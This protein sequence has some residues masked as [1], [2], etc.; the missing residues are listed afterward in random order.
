MNVEV[1]VNLADAEVEKAYKE[2]EKAKQRYR[3]S[4][5]E[6]YTAIGNA[7]EV[8]CKKVD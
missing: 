8:E 7:K 3:E 5:L 1:C 4:L 6:L 2:M